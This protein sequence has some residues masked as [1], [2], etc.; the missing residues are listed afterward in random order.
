MAS[1]GSFTHL[2]VH[3]EFSLLDGLGRIHDL[4][5]Q[6]SSL[7][8]DSLALTDHDGLHGAMEMAQALKPLGV[9]PISSTRRNGSA[10]SSPLRRVC[11]AAG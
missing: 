2:H 11:V 10:V 5:G 3:S 6:A 4:V 9:R 1:R 7:G 8:F